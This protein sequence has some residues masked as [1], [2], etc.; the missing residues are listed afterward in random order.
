VALP[1]HSPAASDGKK[2]TPARLRRETA[3]PPYGDRVSRT[4]APQGSWWTEGVEPGR[5]A[6]ALG[7]AVALTVVVINLALVGELTLF[8]D[9]CFVV[10]CLGLA[11]V[12]QP[13]DFFAVGVLPPLIM[14]AVFT[15]LGSVAP[16]TVADAGDGVAQAV[17]SG[18]AHHSTA[19]VAGYVLCLGT[20]ALRR[21][22]L[23]RDA[24]VED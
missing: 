1:Q 5:Q 9:L 22:T 20:L 8:F 19:L 15:L 12:V 13:R 3:H 6:V 21:R 4:R 14:V 17:V 16:A 18:L 11:V 7:V 10:L 23:D 2:T 24:L